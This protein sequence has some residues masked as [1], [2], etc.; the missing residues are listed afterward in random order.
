LSPNRPQ[1]GFKIGL[2]STSN[3]ALNRSSISPSSAQNRPKFIPKIG[4][5]LVKKLAYNWSLNRP[6]I[7][8]KIGL[9]RCPKIAPLLNICY[10]APCVRNFKKIGEIWK[11]FDQTKRMR[12]TGSFFNYPFR[13]YSSL[14]ITCLEIKCKNPS[15][16]LFLVICYLLF[17]ISWLQMATI[18]KQFKIGGSD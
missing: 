15:V 12:P 18:S 17:L 9:K 3:R 7:G 6:K 14:K 13:S 10:E 5:K 11:K 1:N 2:K 16:F 4:P 8:P